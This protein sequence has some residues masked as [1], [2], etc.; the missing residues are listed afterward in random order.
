MKGIGMVVINESVV[1]KELK[2]R[3]WDH[4]RLASEMGVSYQ[5]VRNMLAGEHCGRK[6]EMG[7][8]N[9]FKGAVPLAKLFKLTAGEEA[10]GVAE[11]AVV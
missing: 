6:G 5:S 7:L 10:E 11:E 8:Y 2:R 9:A 1:S 4:Y 3:D